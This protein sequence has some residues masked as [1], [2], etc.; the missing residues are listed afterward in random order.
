M[1]STPP[2]TAT[3]TSPISSST[4]SSAAAC[5]L[6]RAGHRAPL[7]GLGLG[8]APPAGARRV[9]ARRP[10]AASSISALA[11]RSPSG[12]V[13]RLTATIAVRRRDRDLLAREH[14]ARLDPPAQA[15]RRGL[16]EAALDHR[17]EPLRARQHLDLGREPAL[18]AERR[19]AGR[20]R[21]R[22]RSRAAHRGRRASSSALWSS[23]SKAITATRSS[24]RPLGGRL[25]GERAQHVAE[26]GQAPRAEADARCREAPGAR[27][28]GCG[29]HRE[30]AQDRGPGRRHP[31]ARDAV[32]D[33]RHALEQQ[34]G[35]RRRHR[36]RAMRGRDP[37]AAQGQRRAREARRRRAPRSAR[38]RRP[39][40]RSNPSRRA[41]GSG[42][43]RPRRRGPAP[44]RRRARRRSRSRARATG[45]RQRRLAQARAD[46][47]EACRDRGRAGLVAPAGPRSRTRRPVSTPSSCGTSSARQSVRQAGRA[48]RG[49]GAVG[50]LGPGVE[51]RGQ[52]HVAG[53]AAQRVEMD[54]RERHAPVR[55]QAAGRWTGTT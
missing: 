51:Q 38:R 24:A 48:H 13:T 45:R 30:V 17:V 33:H 21:A 11:V 46:R 6:S 12:R 4:A 55:A 49:E 44:R 28:A 42:P 22:R 34:R 41:R 39:R 8:I 26:A 40:R 50:M 18:L 29:A 31:L 15:D 1:L 47:A 2:L 35:R 36:Q 5:G 32:V 9:A 16:G 7:Q 19:R 3:A 37:A 52:E 23:T 25:V 20:R 10:R 54:V 27:P 53:D 43:R 14:R